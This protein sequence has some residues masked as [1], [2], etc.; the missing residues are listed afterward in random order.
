MT[1]GIDNYLDNFINNYE[2]KEELVE[3]I[4]N[5]ILGRNV[6]GLD[7]YSKYMLSL[8]MEKKL[9]KCMESIHLK[10]NNKSMWEAV[11]EKAPNLFL[12]SE[13]LDEFI[14]IYLDKKDKYVNSN[15]ETIKD[16]EEYYNNFWKI[17]LAM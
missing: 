16:I 7:E 12:H 5:I 8:D 9:M 3:T 10:V 1:L 6:K 4:R 17:L 2:N 11:K 13:S 14:K 15:D